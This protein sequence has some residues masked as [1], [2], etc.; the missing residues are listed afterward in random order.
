MLYQ[1]YVI[2]C[3]HLIADAIYIILRT[4]PILLKACGQDVRTGITKIVTFVV[5][6]ICCVLYFL[7]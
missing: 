3:L 5:S 2:D 1:L 7:Y 4:F 6:T